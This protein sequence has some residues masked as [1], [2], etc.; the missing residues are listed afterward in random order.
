[1]TGSPPTSSVRELDRGDIPLRIR[2]EKTAGIVVED[3]EEGLAEEAGEAIE[4]GRH[5]RVLGKRW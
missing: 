5:D 4:G 3:I 2:S 1:M